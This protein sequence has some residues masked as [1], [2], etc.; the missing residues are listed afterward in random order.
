MGI[1]IFI[2][3]LVVGISVYDYFDS[4]SWQSATSVSRNTLIF[5]HRNKK[6]GAYHMRRDYNDSLGIIIGLF[7]LAI[8]LLSIVNA[9]IRTTPVALKM[10]L[11][12]TTLLTIAAPPMQEIE[13]L[14]TPFKI[15]GGG[16]G[17]AG[18]PSNDPVDKSPKEQTKQTQTID[19]SD[20]STQSGSSTRT[21]GNNPD[22]K[23]TTLVRAPNPFG[24]GGAASGEGSGRFGKDDGPGSGNGNGGG[25]NG[26]GGGA[27][28][29]GSRKR[30]KGINADDIESNVDCTIYLK[31]M[32]NAEGSVVS[33]VNDSKRTTTTNTAFINQIIDLV[34]KQV[35]YD[36]REGAAMETTV[37][38]INVKAT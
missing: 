5:E 36:K 31:V 26:N 25:T 11:M 10:P 21:N 1:I 20:N 18:S 27:G 19:K 17:R 37:Y 33:A 24:G 2:I 6:Y 29:G 32:I 22:N 7:V 13:T 8:A 38:T 30:L 14:P 23:A 28:N 12:D 9:S 34:K 3:V 16:G 35:K 4:R 15:V